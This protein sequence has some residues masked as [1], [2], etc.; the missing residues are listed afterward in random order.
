MG[1]NEHGYI[2]A[3]S[4]CHKSSGATSYVPYGMRVCSGVYIYAPN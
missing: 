3:N 1:R 4:T 2:V